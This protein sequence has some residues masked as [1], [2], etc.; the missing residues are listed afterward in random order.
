MQIGKT[1]GGQKMTK[2]SFKTTT[3]IL[4]LVLTL[5]LT[6]SPALAQDGA[7]VYLQPVESTDDAITVDVFVENI[8]NM[9]GA[10]F[11]LRY[12]PEVLAAQD[13]IPDQ[14]GMQIEVGTLLPIDKG[15][16]VANKIDEATGEI[17]F[18]MT[19]LNP[20]PPA[21]GS[22]PLARVSFKVLQ[23]SPTVLNVE[24]AKLVAADLQT[25]PSQTGSMNIGSAP[26]AAESGESQSGSAPVTT[27]DIPP[28]AGG[29]SFPWWIIAVLVM[30]LGV[31]ALGALIVMG[32]K[33]KS[34][35]KKSASMKRATST[36]QMLPQQPVKQPMKQQPAARSRPSAFKQ[37]PTVPTD[38]SQK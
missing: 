12:D 32:G 14:N 2:F 33:S 38:L 35:A 3:F 8:S 28:A 24:H 25:I 15:F 37:P 27:V 22:G 18:A 23:N 29:S 34:T 31:L 36:R 5:L 4:L 7:N 6:I 20:A 26:A 9:Y 1:I 10:E 19:L 17:V 11:R 30:V 16:V 13:M 21:E